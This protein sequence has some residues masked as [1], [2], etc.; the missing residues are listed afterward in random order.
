MKSEGHTAASIHKR[1]VEVFGNN[2]PKYSTVTKKIRKMSFSSNH[3]T[4]KEK[5]GKPLDFYS[6]AK[7]EKCIKDFPNSSIRNITQETGVPIATVHR[8]L[9]KVLC[10]KCMH[11]RWIPHTLTESDKITRIELSKKLL[12]EIQIAKRNNF[13]F[14]V[15]GDE[16]WFY[17]TFEPTSKWVRDGMPVGTRVRRTLGTPKIM[18]VIFWTIHGI[19]AIDFIDQGMSFNSEYFI[20]NVLMPISQS[21]SFIAAKK[22]KQ[23]YIIHMDN[24]PIHKSAAC[25]SF[26]SEKGFSVPPHPPYSPDLAPS[27]FFLFGALKIHPGGLKFD[28]PDDI[29]SWIEEKFNG[30]SID[31]LKA[32]FANWEERLNWV[33]SHNGDYYPE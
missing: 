16:S 17:Y 31:T 6:L 11:L 19:R 2:A 5:G 27:D 29:L 7:V 14:F 33:I 21:E 4:N 22:Q 10:Y 23:K 32:V 18:V 25:Q 8:Y 15:T 30:F 13:R 1:L 28:S 3:F 20:N 9:T 24:S 12:A 26:L